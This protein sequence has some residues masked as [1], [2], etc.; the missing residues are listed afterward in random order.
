MTR[1][2]ALH[3]L[4]TQA[5]RL[6]RELRPG[7]ALADAWV[8]TEAAVRS[9]D[10]TVLRPAVVVATCDPP[11]DGILSG[12]VLLVVELRSDHLQRWVRVAVGEVWAPWGAGAVA[13]SG[14]SARIVPA[15]GTLVVGRHPEL[16]AAVALLRPPHEQGCAVG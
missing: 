14:T 3:P 9:Q 11:Y 4:K 13:M 6:A 7:A 10:G 15:D 8:S 16:T 1:N 2:A 5:A 12:G